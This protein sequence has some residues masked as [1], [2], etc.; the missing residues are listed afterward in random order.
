[1]VVIKMAVRRQRATTVQEI[2]ETDLLEAIKKAK[3]RYRTEG[4][5]YIFKYD[6][7]NPVCY[8][9]SSSPETDKETGEK[10]YYQKWVFNNKWKEV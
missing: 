9:A 8:F 4:E 5:F 1:M 7:F 6:Q 2:M 3:S 10:I